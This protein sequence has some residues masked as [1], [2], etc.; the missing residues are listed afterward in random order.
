MQ[1][2]RER[3]GVGLA[4]LCALSGAFA[5]AVARL[6]SEG[7]HPLW[8][9]TATSV[10]AALAA[11]AVLKSRG[12]LGDIFRPGIVPHL[13]LLGALGTAVPF[14][15]LFAGASRVTAIETA[16]CLQSETLYAFL[17]S[18]LVLGH[19]PTLRRVA[20]LL[21]LLA[22][23]ALALGAR[24]L[25]TSAGA[26]LVLATPLAWQA[27]HLFVLRH[28]RGV[29][30]SALTGARY[31]YGGALLGLAAL[32]AGVLSV[33]QIA[34]STRMLPVLA[35]QGIAIAYLGTLAWYG[36][37]ARLDL[38]RTTAIVV[39]SIPLLSLGA[40]FVLLGETASARQIAGLLLTA[41]G[42]FAFATAPDVTAEEEPLPPGAT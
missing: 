4:I 8:V 6:T 19:R 25:G 15:L 12:E 1:S 10:F 13:V 23:V 35:I 21:A 26:W 34:A 27:S 17:G 40:S 18:W 42:V 36:A 11:A 33:E 7:A 24:E 5:P 29:S 28:L 30:P 22:G 32:L 41:A 14:L 2:G 3:A 16:L 38:A 31:V 39:P 9:A 20:S 37:I